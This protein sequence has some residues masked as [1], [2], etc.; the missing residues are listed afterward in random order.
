MISDEHDEIRDELGLE[1]L[2][3][4]ASR[5]VRKV[6]HEGRWFFSVIDVVG[7]LTGSAAPSTYWRVLKHRMREEGSGETVTN[8]N[9]LKMKAPDGRQRLTDAADA[10]TM[11]RIIQSIPSPKAEPFKLWLARV[12]AERLEEIEAPER[13]A[14]RMRRLYRQR[15]YSDEW[16]RARMQSIVARDELTTEWHERGAHEGREFAILTD[17][18]HSGAFDVSTAEHKA[19]KT[20]KARDNLR[21]SMTPLELALTILS[22]TTA[23]ELHR[24]HDA[25]GMGELADDAREAGEVG[26]AAR[27]DVETRLGRPVVSGENAKTLTQRPERQPTL[28][29]DISSE[30][31]DAEPEE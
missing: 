10:A 30:Q 11:L 9:Q 14:D 4:Q 20:L 13:A 18:L 22:E 7:L 12:G 25:Q 3:E 15:G 28:F 23:T 8:C 31:T 21:D 19:L 27:R 6:W 17:I 29:G 24:E 16:I 5:E 2:D 1:A 26:G